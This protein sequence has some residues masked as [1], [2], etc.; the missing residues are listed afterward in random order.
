[1]TCQESQERILHGLPED[2][3]RYCH[4]C[5][6]F[7]EAASEVDAAFSQIPPAPAWLRGRVMAAVAPKPSFLPL[8]LDVVGW[9]AMVITLLAVIDRFVV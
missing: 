7:F 4:E 9:A 8:V 6:A 2:H 3:A 5:S 1:M